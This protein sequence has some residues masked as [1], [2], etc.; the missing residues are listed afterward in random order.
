[1]E[2]D[3]VI[4]TSLRQV[5]APRVDIVHEVVSLHVSLRCPRQRDG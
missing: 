2:C 5:S 4:K 3:S 1:M